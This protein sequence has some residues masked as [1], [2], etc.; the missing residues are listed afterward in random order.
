MIIEKILHKLTLMKLKLPLWY[1]G[2][3]YFHN[4]PIKIISAF[5]VLLISLASYFHFLKL[6]KFES[7]MS[8]RRPFMDNEELDGVYGKMEILEKN[9]QFPF[10]I[11]MNSNAMDNLCN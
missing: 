10:K 4:R 9:N 2:K 3:M 1:N 5:L 8:Y 7:V 11:T 6:G